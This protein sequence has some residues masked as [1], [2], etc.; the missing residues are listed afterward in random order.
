M[1]SYFETHDELTGLPNR[2]CVD[3]LAQAL[4]L[5]AHADLVAVLIE[6]PCLDDALRK[7][8]AGR[9]RACARGDD[10]LARVGEDRYVMLL[11]PRIAAEEE[12]KLLARLSTAI[13]AHVLGITAAFGIARCPEDGTSIEQLLAQASTRIR[14]QTVAH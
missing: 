8:I 3:D 7:A 5:D 13:G 4:H 14:E 9:L 1:H 12:S 10:M 6:L 2:R 11:T